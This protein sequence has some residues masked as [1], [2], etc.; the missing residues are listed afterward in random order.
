MKLKQKLSALSHQIEASKSQNNSI[1]DQIIMTRDQLKHDIENIMAAECTMCGSL[2][3][4][5]LDKEFG[6]SNEQ[7]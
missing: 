6:N 2:M 3:I 4:Q 7:W 1:P 5:K